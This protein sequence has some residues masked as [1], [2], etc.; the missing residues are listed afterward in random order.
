MESDIKL[1]L[2]TTIKI[3]IE[4]ISW[5]KD[6]FDHKSSDRLDFKENIK[7]K[8]SVTGL[9][10]HLADKHPKFGRKA[11]NDPQQELFDYCAVILNGR[12]LSAPAELNTELKEGD[13]VKLT[14]AFY[15]G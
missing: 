14:P 9:L 8:T 3:N 6:D 1:S 5:L 11:F 2:E 12:F 13:S 10:H 7:P 15:G 4:I